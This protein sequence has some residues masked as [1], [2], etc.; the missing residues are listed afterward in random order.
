MRLAASIQELRKDYVLKGETVYALR[1]VTFDIPEGDY[2]AIMG[3]S[4][5]GKSTLGARL[6]AAL[7]VPFIADVGSGL[8]DTRVP[9][10]AG[11]PPP[12]LA[13]EPA[14]GPA[15]WIGALLIFG[16]NVILTV[17]KGR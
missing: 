4:G 16:A 13:A 11:V 9:W 1:G 7:D 10:L 2:V 14:L 12:W 15:G 8:L 5:S 17:R 3:P 6:A